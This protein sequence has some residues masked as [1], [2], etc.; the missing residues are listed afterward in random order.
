MRYMTF[1]LLAVSIALTAPVRSQQKSI[2]FSGKWK[3]NKELSDFGVDRDGKKRR[4]RDSQMKIEQDEKNLKVTI[5]REN[6]EG[7]EQ[8]TKLKY[9]LEGKK[10]KN[11]TDFGKQESTLKWLEKGQI[12]KI[13]SISHIKRGDIEFEMESV[14]LFSIV[15]GRLVIESVRYTP[16]GDM[17]TL[18]VYQKDVDEQEE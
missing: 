17:E 18:E 4:P 14:Q 10:S 15:E 13:S 16:R 3:L 9:S 11:K 8:K 12:L 7:K 1:I 5:I 6:R 2:D